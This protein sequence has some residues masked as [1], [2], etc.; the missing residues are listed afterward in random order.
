M[1]EHAHLLEL[2]RRKLACSCQACALLF[3]QPGQRYRRVPTRIARLADFRMSDAQ[4]DSLLVPINMAFFYR[5][6][7]EG[8]VIGS[9]PSP[10]GAT[11][12]HLELGA[13]QQI[14]D[15]NLILTTMEPDVE[16]LL[17][18]RLG[19]QRGFQ[20]NQHFLLPIDQ[21]FRLVGLVRM[22]WRGLS[23]GDLLWQELHQFF[24]ALEGAAHA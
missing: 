12:S 13:W 10:A 21:C 1:E 5:N 11:E 15:E 23:G 14:E 4:W 16:A 24:G 6:G 9:Y 20:G 19:A 22:H 18:N 7:L 17:V 3:S 8:K 2:E